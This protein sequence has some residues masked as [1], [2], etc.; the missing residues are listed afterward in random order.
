MTDFSI[1]ELKTLVSHESGECVS[2]YMP[3]QRENGQ[4]REAHIRLKNLLRD[5]ETQLGAMNVSRDDATAILAPGHALLDNADFWSQSRE[6]LAL[7]MGKDFFRQFDDTSIAVNFSEMLFV[8]DHFQ[9]KPLL[10]LLADN[11][12]FYILALK[13]D[14]IGLLQATRDSIRP[15][16]LVGAPDNIQDALRE[17]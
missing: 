7:F 13:Q 8:A 4:T 16:D 6:G 17:P 3:I 12:Q 9:I 1:S 2:L 15:V 11:G 14:H 5:A 10:P